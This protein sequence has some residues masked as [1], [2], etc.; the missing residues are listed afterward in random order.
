VTEPAPE[1]SRRLRVGAYT[2]CLDSENRILLCRIAPGYT[3]A[4][5]GFWT[6]PG[7]G[8]EHGEHPRD[9]ALRELEEETGLSA[10]LGELLDVESNHSVFAGRNGAEVD[11][12]GVRIIYRAHVTGE[13][14]RF[15]ASGSTDACGWFSRHELAGI[16]LVDLVEH[17][18]RLVFGTTTEP[19]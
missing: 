16:P 11:F 6:L 3:T 2:V 10:V 1:R 15:E 18:A 17:A 19:A 13:A 9:A 4:Y 7:G 5:E 14:L 8:L 12:H